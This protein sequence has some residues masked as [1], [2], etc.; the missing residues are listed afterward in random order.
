MRRRKTQRAHRSTVLGNAADAV[1]VRVLLSADIAA[2]LADQLAAEPACDDQAMI[3]VELP[4]DMESQVELVTDPI[5]DFPVA[6][7]G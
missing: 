2:E 1:E 7:E 6:F 4:Q 3:A 5:V